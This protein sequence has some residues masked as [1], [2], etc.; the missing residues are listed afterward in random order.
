MENEIYRK[1]PLRYLESIP[2][3]SVSNEYTDNYERISEDHL[4]SMR[5]NGTNPFISED[6]WVQC[7]RSTIHLVKKYSRPGDR[8]LDVGVGLGRLLSHFPSLQRYGMDISSGYLR[9]AK[10]KG[11][12]VCYALVED[13]P[14]K[15]GLFDIVVSTDVLEH[16]VDLNLC[17]LKILSV[18]KQG[19]TLIV[20]V[21]YKEDLSQYSGKTCSYKFVHLRTFGENDL[22]LF[23]ERVFGCEHMETV[24]AGYAVRQNRLRYLIPFPRRDFILAYL[25]RGMKLVYERGYEL[26]VK[27]LYDPVVINFVIKKRT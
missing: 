18:L 5:R 14:Y 22:P 16:V 23:F 17:C 1:E 11:I 6:L 13:M 24:R 26:A 20:R 25:F 10:A 15:E 2:V 9:I 19:G 21:P 3:F 7:E 4:E 12:D 27:K 8:I